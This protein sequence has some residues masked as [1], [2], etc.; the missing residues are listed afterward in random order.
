MPSDEGTM[1]FSVISVFFLRVRN[2]FFERPRS[3]N[4]LFGIDEEAC[5]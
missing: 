2:G 5:W 3:A 1:Y 4:C